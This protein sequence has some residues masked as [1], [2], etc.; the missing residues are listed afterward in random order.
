MS[1]KCPIHCTFGVMDMWTTLLDNTYEQHL[2]TIHVF[3]SGH[4][5]ASAMTWTLHLFYTCFMPLT[6]SLGYWPVITANCVSKCNIMSCNVKYTLF[7]L[8]TRLFSFIHS[9]IC[10]LVSLFVQS[11]ICLFI[12]FFILLGSEL[13][14]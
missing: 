14:R 6:L 1:S 5:N 9:F 11:L 12:Y 7:G 13:D 8:Q 3:L 10:S 4:L 2:W